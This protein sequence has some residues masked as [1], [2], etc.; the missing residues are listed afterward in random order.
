ML[1]ETDYCNFNRMRNLNL[2]EKN[3]NR[4]HCILK[5]IKN[6]KKLK[7]FLESAH[8]NHTDTEN[9]GQT[10]IFQNFVMY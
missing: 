4:N 2:A 1:T 10:K 7:L 6:R 9:F 3:K 8:E 5:T